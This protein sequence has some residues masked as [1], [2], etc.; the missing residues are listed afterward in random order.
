MTRKLSGLRSMLMAKTAPLASLAVVGTLA[1]VV[2][3]GCGSS[4]GGKPPAGDGGSEG[5][6]GGASTACSTPTIAPAAGA[7]AAGATVTLTDPGLPANGFI[8]YTTD[9]TMP[10]TASK[11]VMPG[12]TIVVSSSETITAAAF[13]MGSCS[14]STPATAIYT[15]NGV[16]AGPVIT[17]CAPPTFTPGSGAITTGSTVTLVPPADFPTTFPQ[18]NA[19]IYYTTDG[20]V[21]THS[22]PAYSGPIQVTTNNET[23][24]AVADYPGTCSDSSAALATYTLTL[25]EAGALEPPVFN[26]P[27][28]TQSND[29]LVQLTDND[30]AATICF[31]YGTG[32]PTCTVTTTAATC[33]GTSQTYNAGAGLGTTGSVTINS[34]VT[35]ATT[36][37][38]TVNAI[39]CAV[40]GTTTAPVAQTYTLK[41]AAPTMQ[42]PAPSAT[43]PYLAAGYT[44]TLTSATAGSTVRYTTDG[45]TPT[46]A[47]GTLL[48]ANPGAVP[49]F[50]ANST[51]NAIA[52]KTG[53][54]PSPVGGPFA[55]G[56]V[57]PTPAFVD[58]HSPLVTEGTG[59][60][61][62]APTVAF[63]SLGAQFY[64]STTDSSA[65]TCGTTANTCAHGTAGVSVAVTATGTVVNAVA[66]SLVNNSS[67]AGT[68]TYTLQLDPPALNLPGCT[69]TNNAATSCFA[70]P[71]TTATGSYNIPATAALTFQTFVQE[72]LGS[73]PPSDLGVQPTYQFVCAEKT[74]T[75]S[76]TT[77][78]CSAGATLLNPA[79][80]GDF[81]VG[82][83]VPVALA[84]AGV[85]VAGDTW[86]LIGCPGSTSTGFLPSKVTS[87]G[88]AL[89]G[90]AT[91]PVITAATA[92][93][94]YM[95]PI[96]PTFTNSGTAAENLCYGI[97]PT[98][99]PPTTVV[100]CT[101]GGGCG[102]V[103]GYPVVNNGGTG[104]IALGIPTAT[105]VASA[106]VTAGG[107]GYTSAPTVTFDNPPAGNGALTAQGAA[108]VAYSIGVPPAP[109]TGGAGC[110]STAAP[111][112][113]FTG[114][115]GTG[116]TATATI[117][118][119][120]V[121]TGLTI[122]TPGSGYTTAP[123]PVFTALGCGTNPTFTPTLVNG[124]VTGVT[125]SNGGVGYL[126]TPNITITGG[127]GTG[128]TAIATLTATPPPPAVVGLSSFQAGGYSIDVVGCISG[129]PGS[130]LK[131]YSYTFTEATPTVVD[132][133]AA[134]AAVGAGTTVALGDVLTLTAPSTFTYLA[135]PVVCYT[136]DGT[137]PNPACATAGTTTCVASGGT[138]AV[139]AAHFTT[140]TLTAIACDPG[141]Q[142]IQTNSAA[143]SAALNVVV[144]TPVPTIAAGTYFNTV[145]PTLTEASNPGAG[146]AVCY[147]TDGA[148][149]TCAAG[150]CTGGTPA[151]TAGTHIPVTATGTT[152]KAIAC[153]S[154]FS[155]AL[156]T[157][158]YTL[159]VSPLILSNVP[160]LP[161]SYA[162]ADCPGP[163]NV[164]LDCSQ[165]AGGSLGCS[166]ATFSSGGAT[167]GATVCYSTDG[168]A[169]N[170][171][172]AVAG[173][174]TC[175]A[176]GT[177]FTSVNALQSTPI[178][179]IQA[180][181]CET[182]FNP[183]KATLPVTV[184]PYTSVI[185]FTGVPSTDFVVAPTD[186]DALTGS[187]G[188]TGYLS[189]TGTT[190]YVGLSGVTP[191]A[192][193]DTIV[194]FGN[195]SATNAATVTSPGA[196]PIGADLNTAAGF[197]YAFQFPT[198]GT[199]GALYA[200]NNATT[201][202]V[203]QGTAPTVTLNATLPSTTE[204]FSLPLSSLTQ[205]GANP[206]TITVA[207]TE[208]TGAGAVLWGYEGS[209][210]TGVAIAGEG[211]FAH[212]FAY[213][214]GS[215]LYPND[216]NA[217]E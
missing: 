23:I 74:A 204:E 119:A 91:A 80:A 168:T 89:P 213:P 38:V 9:Q 81:Q 157:T 132:T 47:T 34:G 193:T 65:P 87:V 42:G 131:T 107:T 156:S 78:G 93:G 11:F 136:T 53:Y 127:G 39:A 84:A 95:N 106:A 167:A 179:G 26:P 215:C 86:N 200:W 150:A 82:A 165:G 63:S 142:T 175:A 163:I 144:A 118:S 24:R 208:V 36:G 153:T 210:P 192:T 108:T 8:Y 2:A 186:E 178:A 75:P 105:T 180:L 116:A 112:I 183:S 64:C 137:A 152:I 122:T 6:E 40:G 111:I 138:L 158:L 110:T 170:S 160:A 211:A 19:V 141:S 5:G 45:S 83:A 46:C 216:P 85:V 199:A 201:A 99:T 56:I 4:G 196:P 18:G 33:S 164:G 88:F 55:Y 72:T 177:L 212:W 73:L 60:Y 13:A 7:I 98:A 57:L 124:V 1:C 100:N 14:L 68:A 109:L 10:T 71:P 214:T 12:G 28:A 190:L 198:T 123:T 207:E 17:A 173:H 59:T 32:A 145:S 189:L 115:G 37:T 185:N 16:D 191:A 90:A 154:A 126:T 135:A 104:G 172:V 66:C 187:G 50:T 162:N 148:T 197:Q 15:V 96:T 102:A 97:Y 49:T 44:P 139:T 146:A 166:T 151:Y 120:N 134:G 30:A 143:F 184:T 48:G 171:C 35:N 217:R 209:V 61:D 27:S 194:Y 121:V 174:I 129:V 101:A 169:V 125:V 77:T 70:N 181:A 113:T 161:L 62:G 43:L 21:P 128:A 92:P 205:L 188:L 103:A 79:G 159:N 3:T 206:A 182:N 25:P 41:G 155:S 20:T 22:S 51:F 54:A 67:A 114:G 202:W 147:T 69:E 94:N 76:C 176:P 195:G 31:T 149:P 52:C 29:F 140:N 203:L 133:T 117:N 58:N 130:A